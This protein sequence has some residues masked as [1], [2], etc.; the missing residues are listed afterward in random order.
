MGVTNTTKV[1]L[2]HYQNVKDPYHWHGCRLLVYY[3]L[4]TIGFAVA[5]LMWLI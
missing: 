4:T 1:Y 2:S 5:S 3:V